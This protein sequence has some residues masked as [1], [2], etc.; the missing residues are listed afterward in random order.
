M[1]SDHQVAHHN[2]MRNLFE[3]N[4]RFSFDCYGFASFCE[5]VFQIL[6]FL[7]AMVN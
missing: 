7:Q 1:V 2:H 4:H 5:D 6:L 3:L